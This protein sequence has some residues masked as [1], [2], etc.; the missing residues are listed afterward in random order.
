M[1]QLKT[2]VSLNIDSST[3]STNTS[4]P[5][6]RDLRDIPR[7][8][9]DKSVEHISPDSDECST[10]GTPGSGFE[11]KVLQGSVLPVSPD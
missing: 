5:S 1:G 7:L 2:K 6:H 9:P 3:D 4:I 11:N 8:T 10:P